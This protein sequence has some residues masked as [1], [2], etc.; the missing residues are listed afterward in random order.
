M[1]EPKLG[2][3]YGDVRTRVKRIMTAPGHPQAKANL[4]SSLVNQCRLAEGEKAI[5]ELGRDLSSATVKERSHALSGAG[6]KQTGWGKGK[7]LGDG[8]WRYADGQWQRID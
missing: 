1:S 3:R 8:K 2:M 5:I 6:S 4:V 7:R